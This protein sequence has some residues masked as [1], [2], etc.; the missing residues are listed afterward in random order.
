MRAAPHVRALWAALLAVA[1]AHSPAR[2]RDVA[3]V[4]VAGDDVPVPVPSRT[5]VLKG[6]HLSRVYLQRPVLEALETT[7]V[8]RARDVNAYD[9]VP[10]SSWF[11]P[12]EGRG[13]KELEDAYAIVGKPKP[14]FRILD[15][16]GA[17][18]PG[19]LVV[20]DARGHR[21]E[22]V[23]DH[24]APRDTRTAAAA[25]GSRLA[26]LAGWIA[27]ETWVVDL[28]P[29]PKPGWERVAAVHWSPGIDVGPTPEGRRRADDPN[30]RIAHR[31]RRSL[32]ALGVLA[33]WL[34]ARNLGPE[35]TRDA[36]V[37]RRGAGHVR[38][39]VVGF[40]GWLGAHR[41]HRHKK[42]ALPVGEVSGNVFT[43]LITFGL[44]PEP[45]DP[46]P[47]PDLRAF[48]PKLR[49]AKWRP[50]H[51]YEPRDRMLPDDAY[52]GAKRLARIDDDAMEWAVAAG[53]IR[54]AKVARHLID[55]LRSRRQDL[56]RWAY[57]EVTPCEVESLNDD[58]VVLRDEAVASDLQP[59][60]ATIY[61]V[62]F[63]DE[64]GDEL[65]PSISVRPSR[66]T[67]T[68]E[69]PEKLRGYFIL[70]VLAL[71]GATEGARPMEVHAIR[72]QAGTRVLG[73]RH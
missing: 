7:R 53:K 37:G 51:P 44:R 20:E 8:P 23:R 54:D 65:F 52:W 5:R 34:D 1:C 69:L 73:I 31:D 21:W 42:E 63:L 17:I 43:N 24:P 71:R 55:A 57:A 26:R 22:L 15:R 58:E 6:T 70:R 38:H 29:A 45:T 19:A 47:R 33:A 27:P 35:A 61:A 64:D 30:D 12:L 60:G 48:K 49:A 46:T 40:S 25:I 9:E 67:F 62:A 50:R 39:Y 36:Y 56:T 72:D 18:E 66:A 68:V 10:R 4:G 3:A 41:T 16:K 28:R 14:P 13:A 11:D 32:R 59:G 2:Y